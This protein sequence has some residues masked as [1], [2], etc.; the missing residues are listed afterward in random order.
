[1]YTIQPRLQI[2]TNLLGSYDLT[3]KYKYSKIKFDPIFSIK[4]QYS[5]VKLTNKNLPFILFQEFA[6]TQRFYFF[7]N[8]KVNL[9]K[10]FYVTLRNSCLYY[11]V[12]FL[13]N[14]NL[15]ITKL[16]KKI[17]SSY[18]MINSILNI[19]IIN[20]YINFLNEKIIFSTNL[21]KI[22]IDLN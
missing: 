1:M 9:L 22:K 10:K 16:K 11:Y 15:L 7:R 12:E 4:I 17:H 13:T 19:N 5:S 2:Y 21:N 8:K 20:F 3:D 18:N 6:T 14:S